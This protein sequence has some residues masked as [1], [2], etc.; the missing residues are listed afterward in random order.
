MYLCTFAFLGL[1]SPS[2][3]E[4]LYFGLVLASP[5]LAEGRYY[6]QW[7]VGES[8]QIQAYHGLVFYQVHF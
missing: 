6:F 3:S 7:S 4:S 2:N 5:S 1:V 8:Q